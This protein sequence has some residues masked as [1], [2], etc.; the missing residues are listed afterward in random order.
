MTTR[1]LSKIIRR[2]SW[3]LRRTR[4]TV[5]CPRCGRTI[6]RSVGV[7]GNCVRVAL[8]QKGVCC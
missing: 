2:T 6:N 3:D 7:C 4:T 8:C 1:V 5:D